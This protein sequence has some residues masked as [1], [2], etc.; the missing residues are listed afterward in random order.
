MYPLDL[1]DQYV[2]GTAVVDGDCRWTY[3]FANATDKSRS[4]DLVNPWNGAM[5]DC[6]VYVYSESSLPSDDSML[7]PVGVLSPE[8]GVF[9]V[10]IPAESV[11]LLRQRN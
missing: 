4:L 3:V 8:G 7:A 5:S 10:E 6:D 11:V 9:N 1:K 2:A